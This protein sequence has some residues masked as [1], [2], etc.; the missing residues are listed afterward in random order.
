MAIF[1]F[2]L[3]STLI[4]VSLLSKITAH[5]SFTSAFVFGGIY[6]RLLPTDKEILE[7][8]GLTKV[9]SKG[10]RNNGTSGGGDGRVELETFH[11]PRTTPLKLKSAEVQAH[12]IAVLPFYTELVW[13]V[14]FSVCA[15][16]VLF[17]NDFVSFCRQILSASLSSNSSNSSFFHSMQSFF[18]PSTINLNLVWA[19]LVVFFALT[20]LVS[21]LRV[22]L[23]RGGGNKKVEQ[24]GGSNSEWPLIMVAGFSSF[25]F[26][27]FCLSLDENFLDLRISPA[28]G[29]LTFS[30]TSNTDGGLAI[31]WGMFQA[32]LAS[33]AAII[34]ML[35]TFPSLQYG[36]VYIQTLQ[37]SGISWLTRLLFH[38]NLIAPQLTLLLWVVP[39]TAR[40]PEL[41]LQR[42]SS[43]IGDKLGPIWLSFSVFCARIFSF[44]RIS[45]LRL[46]FT[47]IT[48][49]L[50]VAMT[51]M[52]MQAFLDTAQIRLDRLSHEPGR[53]TN[54]E[55]Q[56]IVASV[57]HCFNFAALQYLAPTIL[58]IGLAC[59]YKV[60]TGTGWLPLNQ[61]PV[62]RPS[63]R[64]SLPNALETVLQIFDGQE[65][66]SVFTASWFA[67]LQQ[68]R[69]A[70]GVMWDSISYQASSVCEG[71][72][73]F[74]LFW[75]LAVWQAVTVTGTAY[76][77]F[78]E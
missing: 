33:F 10:K 49:V 1:G 71:V 68:T 21:V 65:W 27:M 61:Q 11:F 76:Y 72:L 29:N 64:H 78:V 24:G 51:K 18:A 12:E 26:A 17:V 48:V 45:S 35:F 14:D 50:R 57:F 6:R 4:G 7:S 30:I 2:Q 36:R 74:A 58:L 55:V 52:H 40:L 39:L 77:R 43:G 47:L 62:F 13:L 32:G 67:V 46:L 54:I 15:M 31:S 20:S 56:R 69:E 28:Y 73:G 23:G 37:N 53:V 25:V 16:T 66:D 63:E 9:K 59:S 70:F 75:C 34:G 38:L 60:S 3:V 44:E 22:Y 19:L 42:A 5:F 8:A 41:M